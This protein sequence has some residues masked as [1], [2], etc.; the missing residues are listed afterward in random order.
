MTKEEVEQ[1]KHKLKNEDN[2]DVSPD[3]IIDQLKIFKN[4]I[5]FVKLI[6]PC[7]LNDGVKTI[8][9]NKQKELIDLFQMALDS[10]RV[11]KFVPAS[12]A[13]TRRLFCWIKI[14]FQLR[15]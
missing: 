1:L 10:G 11:M 13:A 15:N 2:L 7:V 9:S 12:G 14:E 4:G 3:K 8:Q 6:K 5:P